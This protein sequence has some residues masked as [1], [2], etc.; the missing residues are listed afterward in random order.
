[1]KTI[2]NN[3]ASTCTP[4]ATAALLAALSG[5]IRPDPSFGGGAEAAVF[6]LSESRSDT[7]TKENSLATAFTGLTTDLYA[8]DPRDQH[9]TATPNRRVIWQ[10]ENASS[11]EVDAVVESPGR[12]APAGRT[13][14][15]AA[16]TLHACRRS[17]R[18]N[19]AWRPR[20]SARS[21][22]NITDTLYTADSLRLDVG[23]FQ[24]DTR[25]TRST[26][27][28]PADAAVPLRR[29][30][31]VRPL[32]RRVRSWAAQSRGCSSPGTARPKPARNSDIFQPAPPRRP[33]SRPSKRSKRS[34][35]R[36][37][38]RADA[39]NSIIRA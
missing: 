18:T 36:N 2:P 32:D 34:T 7:I 5:K 11:S 37:S 24:I 33:T 35:T 14:P 20:T 39:T 16:Q 31:R 38:G 8:D 13:A 4:A 22:K 15:E 25:Q 30:Q 12:H 10:A 6:G 29:N 28:N 27:S 23:T 3:P 19:S 9:R 21:D 1:M 26:T 17:P